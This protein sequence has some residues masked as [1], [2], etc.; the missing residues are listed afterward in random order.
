MASGIGSIYIQFLDDNMF[1]QIIKSCTRYLVINF[2]DFFQVWI[3]IHISLALLFSGCISLCPLCAHFCHMCVDGLV[4][5]I[6]RV[7]K[8]IVATEIN[9]VETPVIVLGLHLI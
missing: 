1:K 4:L 8:F 2:V 7:L 3:Y 6:V 5:K 9:D